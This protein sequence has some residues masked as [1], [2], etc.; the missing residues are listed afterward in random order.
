M[1]FGLAEGKVKVRSA[2]KARGGVWD[3]T[4][5]EVVVA[6][7]DLGFRCSDTISLYAEEPVDSPVRGVAL[8]VGT[9]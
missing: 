9:A 2:R 8:V 7:G 6:R 1:V 3:V 4:I 5:A